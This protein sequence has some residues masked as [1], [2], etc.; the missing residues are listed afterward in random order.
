MIDEKN[1]EHI[2]KTLLD[3]LLTLVLDPNGI[4]VIKKLVNGNKEKSIQNSILKVIEEHC[5]EIIQSPYG[6]YIIQH[7]LDEWGYMICKDIV[8]VIYQNLI[9]LSMQK[10]AS[11]VVEK[12]LDMID[13]VK[14]ILKSEYQKALGQGTFQLF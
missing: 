3:N 2:N 7:V 10:F 11:N 9:S 4:C 14:K 8:K 6:N 13:H 1:R 12:C 5:L